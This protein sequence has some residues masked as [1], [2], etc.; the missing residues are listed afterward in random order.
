MDQPTQNMNRASYRVA[1]TQ[2]KKANS[3]R[4]LV[5]QDQLRERNLQSNKKE[6]QPVPKTGEMKLDEGKKTCK[7]KQKRAN[8]TRT[9]HEFS[10]RA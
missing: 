3:M 6:E 7:A 9:S 1:C 2:L 5:R 4:K 8:I 10:F